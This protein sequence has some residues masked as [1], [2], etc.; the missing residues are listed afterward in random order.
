M[1]NRL[2]FIKLAVNGVE[3]NPVDYFY[4]N[5]GLPAVYGFGSLLQRHFEHESLGSVIGGFALAT[6]LQRPYILEGGGLVRF[7]MPRTQH[8]LKNANLS[9]GVPI[10]EECKGYG[11]YGLVFEVYNFQ[12]EIIDVA[13]E[14]I[15]LMRFAGGTIEKVVDVDVLLRGEDSEMKLIRRLMP[16][17]VLIDRHELL[18]AYCRKNGCDPLDALLDHLS[19]VESEDDEHKEQ[20]SGEKKCDNRKAGPVPGWLIPVFAGYQRVF[21]LQQNVKGQ[22]NMD[23]EHAFVEPV[24]TLAQC[25]LPN[26]LSCVN[27]MLWRMT[28]DEGKNYFLFHQAAT[29]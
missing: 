25:M 17:T 3:L 27:E 14:N 8:F 11:V 23:Y 21:D 15:P 20:E 5:V 26:R 29:T 13:Q 18:A 12:D 22:R 1:D 2:L 9:E 4:G 10:M 24:V 6:Y 16:G 7:C 28:M 19:F